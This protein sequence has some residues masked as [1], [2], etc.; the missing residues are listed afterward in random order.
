VGEPTG[1][2]PVGYQDMDSFTLPNSGWRITYSKRN[3]RFQDAFSPG[4]QPD[5][6][7]EGDWESY[8]NGTDKPLVWVMQDIANRSSGRVAHAAPAD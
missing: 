7:V 6:P 8:R 5:T 4:I 1:G 3:Y 2:N